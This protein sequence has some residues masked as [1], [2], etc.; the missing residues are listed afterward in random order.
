MAD[1]GQSLLDATDLELSQRDKY[2]K[3]FESEYKLTHP[4][5]D[6]VLATNDDIGSKA[7][8]AHIS[9]IA[10]NLTTA[11]ATGT[12]FYFLELEV[13]AREFGVNITNTWVMLVS[14]IFA[15][16]AVMGIDFT[17]TSMGLAKGESDKEPHSDNISQW[18]AFTTA[19]TAG[20]FR[21]LLYFQIIPP[22][23]PIETIVK[24]IVLLAI[25]VL[26]VL[27]LHPAARISGY[28]L[29]WVYKENKKRNDEYLAKKEEWSREFQDALKSYITSRVSTASTLQR[30]IANSDQ[31]QPQQPQQPQQQAAPSVGISQYIRQAFDALVA[32]NTGFDPLNI[33]PSD[34]QERLETW[35]VTNVKDG[36]LRPTIQRVKAAVLNDILSDLDT[37]PFQPVDEF[38]ERLSAKLGRD[39]HPSEISNALLADMQ[40]RF[41]NK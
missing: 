6:V 22:G 38:C 36:T 18:A 7:K 30:K 14:G 27:V 41:D 33:K 32:E 40:A 11:G 8:V 35:G 39:I 9:T 10:I 29:G 1:Y 5:R 20:I 17:L 13:L 3:A 24:G 16:A 28:Y 21:G 31:Q 4:L 12:V 37:S 15:L 25:A 34:I 26:P 2:I 23:T 19:A